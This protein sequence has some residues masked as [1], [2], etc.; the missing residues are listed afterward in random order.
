MPG[1]SK[2]TALIIIDVQK[3][4]DVP[5]IWGGAR[6]NL[7]AEDNIVNLLNYWRESKRP[8]V[9]IQHASKRV[10]S[11]L[12]PDKD[13]YAI[14]DAV[15]PIVGETLFIKSKNSAFIGTDL[16]IFLNESYIQN[17]VIVGLTTDHCVS[18]TVRMAANLGFKVTLVSDATATFG[19]QNQQKKLISADD[20]HEI[21]LASLN[22]EFATI[23]STNEV[24][25][26]C[27]VN[28]KN[29]NSFI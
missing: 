16:E 8:V 24:I 18:T 13:T 19:K 1:I 10:D 6:N 27:K 28:E 3:G 9:H 29:M 4:F 22:N 2:N 26:A 5:D 17:V 7:D 20:I 12:H 21:N 11:P 25:Q 15:T 23:M 14:K